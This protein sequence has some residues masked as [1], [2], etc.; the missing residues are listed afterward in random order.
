MAVSASK[1]GLPYVAESLEQDTVEAA[2][3]LAPTIFYLCNKS[4]M[5]LD[6]RIC[7]PVESRIACILRK[8]SISPRSLIAKTCWLIT[9]K[10]TSVLVPVIKMSSTYTKTYKVALVV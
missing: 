4:M 6:C 9:E 8:K 3:G 10:K 7:N 5:H 1:S 2:Y